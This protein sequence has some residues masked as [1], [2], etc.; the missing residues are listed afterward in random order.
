MNDECFFLSSF[1]PPNESVWD[2]DLTQILA[3][4]LTDSFAE[5]SPKL[6]RKFQSKH[7][8]F[9]YSIVATQMKLE[10]ASRFNRSSFH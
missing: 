5:L 1:Y 8:E 3:L 7:N 10:N 6:Y 4:G 9:H 2:L